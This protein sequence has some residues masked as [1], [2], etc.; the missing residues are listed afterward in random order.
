MRES[1]SAE[2]LLAEFPPV[3]ATDSAGSGGSDYEELAELVRQVMTAASFHDPL[4]RLAWRF[5]RGGMATGKATET[6]QGLL[7]AVP[8][9]HDARW[10]A[11]FDDIE[12]TVTSAAAKQFRPALDIILD[13]LRQRYEPGHRNP[14]QT[15]YSVALGVDMPLNKIYADREVLNALRLATE[16]PRDKRG[17]KESQ[18]PTVFRRHKEG[19]YGELLKSLPPRDD[20]ATIK[21]PAVRAEFE[22]QL[23]ALLKTMVTVDW[24]G[25]RRHSLGAWARYHATLQPGRWCRVGSYDLWGRI[26]A[27]GLQIALLPTLAGQTWRAHH[28]L[29]EMS[30][31][32]LTQRCN[33]C[34]LGVS[35]DDDNRIREAG[36]RFRVAILNEAFVRSLALPDAGDDA[37]AAALHARFSTDSAP[38][39][40]RGRDH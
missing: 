6:L 5:L 35:N 12:R 36:E 4:V 2:Q 10:Q 31:K 11:R 23:A 37:L 16:T 15:F 22:Q 19:A 3:T 28:E 33:V 20:E 25:Q 9:P 17:V 7:L 8:E 14:E 38:D 21:T 39:G 24:G 34:G 26:T 18:L 29:T 1:Y 32:A 40:N 13:W 30:L 27:K